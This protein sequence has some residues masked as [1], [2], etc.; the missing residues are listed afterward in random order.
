M[1]IQTQ[2][3]VLCQDSDGVDTGINSV[4]KR[5]INDSV[6][7][8]KRYCRFGDLG[9][10]DAQSAA[11]AA[12]KQHC[13]HLFLNHVNTSVFPGCSIG[14]KYNNHTMCIISHNMK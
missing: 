14:V 1:G 8:A 5:K 10:K 3:A 9:S 4:G 13:D 2:R 12:G 11:L 7:S 6:L